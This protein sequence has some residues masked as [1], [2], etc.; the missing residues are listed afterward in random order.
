MEAL[1]RTFEWDGMLKCNTP[2]LMANGRGAAG[3]VL[4][5]IYKA[6]HEKYNPMLQREYG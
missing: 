6:V 5:S 3:E 4:Y 2:Q 1:K